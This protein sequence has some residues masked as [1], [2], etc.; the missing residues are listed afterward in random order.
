MQQFVLIVSSI[1]WSS[2]SPDLIC[3]RRLI[4]QF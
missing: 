4:S 3:G 2:I 1:D